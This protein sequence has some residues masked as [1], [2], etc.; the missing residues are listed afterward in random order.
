MVNKTQKKLTLGFTVP[1]LIV[2]ITISTIMMAVLVTAIVAFT[3]QF[4]VSNVRQELNTDAQAAIARINEDVR[5]SSAIAAYN[6]VPDAHAPATLTPPYNS[7][8]GP[9]DETSPDFNW[10]FG[11]GR[12][13]LIQ[14]VKDAAGDTVYS[15]ATSLAN[16]TNII[17]YYVKDNTLFRRVIAGED[18]ASPTLTC[19]TLRGGCATGA[20]T[21][22]KIVS[23]LATAD[24]IGS[25]TVNYFD[26]TGAEITVGAGT[27]EDYA[28]FSN[29]RLISVNI[30][31]QE[32]QVNHALVEARSA[33]I[34]FRVEPAVG[35]GSVPSARAAI[36]V[37]PGG[38][39]NQGVLFTRQIITSGP[40]SLYY[41]SIGDK[42]NPTLINASN[43]YCGTGNAYATLQCSSSPISAFGSKIFGDICAANQ[44][45]NSSLFYPGDT[46][47]AYTRG[48]INPC[49]PSEVVLPTFDKTAFAASMTNSLPNVPYHG[50]TCNNTERYNIEANT[51]YE[52]GSGAS[53]GFCKGEIRGSAYIKG[54]WTIGQGMRLQVSESVGTTRP[55]I[56]V[57]GKISFRWGAHIL[58]NSHGTMPYII[59][60]ESSNSA[61]SDS[62]LNDCLTNAQKESSVDVDAIVIDGNN[63]S[64]PGLVFHAYYGEFRRPAGLTLCFGGTPCGMKLGGVMAQKLSIGF[65]ASINAY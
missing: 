40:I 33:K 16:N 45:P 43:K 65:G 12:L 27:Q 62:E 57:N 56:V 7:V 59:S 28:K 58:P 30:K 2:A 55:I 14:P 60:F 49:T 50:A 5:N 31:L 24:G 13:I 36:L 19:G 53:P 8:P 3:Q 10:R 63:N 20:V 48:L 44:T 34:G 51:T 26:Q 35:S 25:F 6:P 11:D 4:S 17:V 41:G 38:I 47:T 29:A 46:G 1:E 61:C 15:D 21:D 64:M 54:N 39:N 32:S 42:R 52:N 18:N 37:G 23:N 22:T 9:E